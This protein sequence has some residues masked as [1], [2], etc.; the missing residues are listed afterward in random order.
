MS[1]RFHSLTAEIVGGSIDKVNDAGFHWCARPEILTMS[2]VGKV[3][4]SSAALPDGMRVYAI[5]DIHGRRD[6]LE[7]LCAQ[8]DKDLES[9]PSAVMTVFLGDYVDRG[10]DS[11]GVIE[12]LAER[13]FP[14][15]FCALRGNHE[16][17]LLQFLQDETLLESWRKFGGLETLHSYGVDVT[18]PMRGRGYAMARSAFMERIPESHLIFLENTK[19]GVAYGDFFFVHAGVRPGVS[20]HAQRADDLLWIRDEFLLSQD[21]WEKVVVHGHTP[22]QAPEVRQN[23]INIDTG[24][25]A[26]SVLTALVLEGAD[27]RFIQT[28]GDRM[29]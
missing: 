28:R 5:G 4:L 29:R 9:A 17:V 11:A 20:L 12:R 22:V 10:S 25:F 16:Q 21:V 6:L 15:P 13:N 18:D 2:S 27:R 8:I 7:D 26:T 24:A 3:T 19:L 1:R 23:R 14:T